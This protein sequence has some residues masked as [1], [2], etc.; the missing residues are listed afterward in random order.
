M[1]AARFVD[2]Q[3]AAL[4]PSLMLRWVIDEVALVVSC[5]LSQ[6]VGLT[7]LLPRTW[8]GVKPLRTQT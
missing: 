3:F 4:L 6:N 2:S 7:E 1:H 5:G 8:F